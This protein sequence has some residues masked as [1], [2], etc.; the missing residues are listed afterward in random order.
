[1]GAIGAAHQPKTTIGAKINKLGNQS[2]VPDERK[3]SPEKC[4]SSAS[5]IFSEAIR[6][7]KIYRRA[8]ITTTMGR[9]LQV[10]SSSSTRFPPLQ[11]ASVKVKSQ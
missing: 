4:R 3:L 2:R 8:M 6:T 5:I 11:H 7:M 1:M 9:Y 10:L